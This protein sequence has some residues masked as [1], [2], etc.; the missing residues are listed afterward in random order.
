M[1]QQKH[2]NSVC[3]TKGASAVFPS[4]I[5]VYLIHSPLVLLKVFAE[6]P[7]CYFP[8]LW[9]RILWIIIHSGLI[10]YR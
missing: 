3:H 7:L 1:K 8:Y 10:P 4:H 6:N 2:K 5:A 9:L